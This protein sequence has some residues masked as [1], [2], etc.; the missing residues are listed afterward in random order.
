MAE[1]IHA[2]SQL[3]DDNFLQNVGDERVALACEMFTLQELKMDRFHDVYAIQIQYDDCVDVDNL[4]K[5]DVTVGAAAEEEEALSV[6]TPFN[7]SSEVVNFNNN[8]SNHIIKHIAHP[9]DSI[10]DIKRQLQSIYL[11][12]WGLNGRRLDRDKIAIGWEIVCQKLQDGDEVT[13]SDDEQSVGASKSTSNSDS[14]EVMSYHLF[15]HSYGISDGNI[16]YAIVRKDI[17]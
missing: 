6:N 11:N 12:N 16:I 3:M 10:S 4:V 5:D 2:Y 14:L 13:N 15:L 1:L 17:G 8:N 9:D 7:T